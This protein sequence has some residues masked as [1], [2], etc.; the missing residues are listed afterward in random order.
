M[1]TIKFYIV[2]AILIWYICCTHSYKYKLFFRNNEIFCPCENQPE[3]V[4]DIH[5]LFDFSNVHMDFDENEDV[6]G[7]GNMTAVWDIQ[8]SDMISVIIH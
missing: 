5:G 8:P 7:S 2:G 4:L 6:I 1:Y 3:N